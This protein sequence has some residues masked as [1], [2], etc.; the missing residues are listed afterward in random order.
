MRVIL[1]ASIL[2]LIANFSSNIFARTSNVNK[3]LT[4]SEMIKICQIEQDSWS[5]PEVIEV[6]MDSFKF[7]PEDIVLQKCRPYH[8]ILTNDSS[9]PH[10]FIAKDFFKTVLLKSDSGS[11]GVMTD[12][13]MK[14]LDLKGHEKTE[15]IFM[16]VVVGEYSLK[17][18]HFGHA[19]MGMKGS[20]VV[21]E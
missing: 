18:T 14:K 6:S 17:C 13:T 8:L 4:V 1:F 20:I 2:V 11:V 3:A 12:V 9:I 10:D 19:V 7:V 5:I 16:P 15:L 21:A